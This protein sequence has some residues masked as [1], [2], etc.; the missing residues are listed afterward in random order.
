MQA[1]E[2]LKKR[3]DKKNPDIPRYLVAR[4]F[5]TLNAM[6]TL[7]FVAVNAMWTLFSMIGL[8]LNNT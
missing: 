2:K 4:N 3:V 8:T 6:W 7:N 5:C 1:L